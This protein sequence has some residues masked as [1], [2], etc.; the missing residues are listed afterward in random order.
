MRAGS[1]SSARAIGTPGRYTAIQVVT[2]PGFSQ[3][4]VAHNLR[5]ALHD[6]TTE[7]LTGTQATQEAQKAA[8]AKLRH[9]EAKP[10]VSGAAGNGQPPDGARRR[11][12]RPGTG[13]GG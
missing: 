3:E 12:G 7:V 8:G 1:S 4:Q 2:A 13:S 6:P 5:A 10:E 9:K 11:P